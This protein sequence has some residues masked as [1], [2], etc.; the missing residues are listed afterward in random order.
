M[1]RWAL[2]ALMFAIIGCASRKPEASALEVVGGRGDAYAAE[3]SGR[4]YE[5]KR[6]ST[7]PRPAML[8]MDLAADE[9]PPPP[10]PEAT[11]DPVAPAPA[12]M[13]HYDGFAQIRATKPSETIDQIAAL[14]LESGGRVDRLSDNQVTVRVPVDTFDDVWA[15]VLDLGDVL[16]KTVRADDITDQFRAVDLRVR[17]LKTMQKRLV[18]LLAKA[19]SEQDKLQLLQQLTRVTEELDRTE[20]ALRKLRDLASLSRI[21]V[22]VVP[23][24]FGAQGQQLTLDGFRWIRQLSPF[25]R[26]VYDDDKRIGLPVPDE[27]VAL[28][29]KGPF[30]AE[31]PDLTVL[32]TMRVDNDPRGD[33]PFWREAIREALASD[34]ADV[35][36]REVGGYACLT[37]DEPGADE[38]YR[39]QVCLATTSR[40]VE[41][42]QTYFPSPVAV[43]RFAQRIDDALTGGGDA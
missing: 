29:Q 43:E 38:P 3:L 30:I 24:Q 19:Q 4:T 41:V 23:R 20:S 32:W 18:R 25:N 8:E 36:P 37:L 5:A 42:V 7:A 21:S 14:A 2:V 35:T 15:A 6:Q 17:T 27:M 1:T 11:I 28:T 9:A 10:P 34:F 31:S 13:V 33:A 22:N 39:W 12:R 26:S 40:H 16:S